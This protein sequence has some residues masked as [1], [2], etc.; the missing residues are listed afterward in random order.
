MTSHI[1]KQKKHED[2]RSR[3]SSFFSVGSFVRS[4]GA[5][6]ASVAAL[7]GTHGSDFEASALVSR[8]G[9]N[10]FGFLCALFGGNNKTEKFIVLKGQFCFVYNIKTSN[11]PMYSI[12]L[13]NLRASNKGRFVLLQT[14]LGDS[15]YE[16]TFKNEDTAERF[17]KK[18]NFLARAAKCDETRKKLG[19]EKLFNT[20]KS[21]LFAQA[22][23]KTK[24]DD[25]PSAPI[26]AIEVLSN[27]NVLAI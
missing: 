22:V 7:R 8:G 3:R 20:T 11:S 6:G 14:V 9:G 21:N 10:S 13:V 27:T 2:T 19:H 26:T 15:E 25:Q 12:E 1:Q 16:F 4:N 17:S 23:G 18:V 5:R 24:L